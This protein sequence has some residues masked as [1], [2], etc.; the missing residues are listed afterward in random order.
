V[1][2]KQVFRERREE[3]RRALHRQTLIWLIGI[4]CLVI[5]VL[6][7]LLTLRG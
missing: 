3:R 1:E 2:R 4:A 7:I 5:V 6:G